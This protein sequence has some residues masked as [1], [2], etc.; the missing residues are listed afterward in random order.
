MWSKTATALNLSAIFTA[1]LLYGC[2]PGVN[3]KRIIVN[4]SDH[5]IM[6]YIYEGKTPAGPY[7]YKQDALL[8]KKHSETIIAET[9]TLHQAREY[10]N[11]YS[12][13]DSIVGKID[14]RDSLSLDIDINDAANWKFSRLKK[15]FGDGG[16]CECRLVIH[17]NDIQ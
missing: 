14:H 2:D 11:C 12:N 16:V 7:A 8:L 15:S 17:H 5:D 9:T 3:Y 10:E 4:Q 13:A 6:L 1:L